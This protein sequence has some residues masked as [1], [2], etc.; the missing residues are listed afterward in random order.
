RVGGD[1]VENQAN[2]FGLDMAAG[3]QSGLF[4][5][6]FSAHGR[7]GGIEYPGNTKRIFVSVPSLRFDL[8]SRLHPAVEAGIFGG[9]GGR[10]DSLQSPVGAL[11]TVAL[12]TLP[13]YG[14][15]AD[16][17]GTE[18]MPMMGN[19]VLE[20]GTERTFGEYRP[21]AA[22][23]G[24]QYPTIWTGY[25]TFQTQWMYP[26]QVEDFRLQPALRFSRRSESAQGYA[27]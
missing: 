2:M 4:R 10:L 22:D 19:V 25:W 15:L 23:S 21:A 26:F 14:V 11:E 12:L 5:V 18:D 7:L 3:P 24:L 9:F 20:L 17:G 1:T 27:G 16:V 13:R 6:G 8:G